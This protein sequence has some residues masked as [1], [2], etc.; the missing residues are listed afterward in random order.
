MAEDG[1][2]SGDAARQA[3]DDLQV[4]CVHC[5][6]GYETRVAERISQIHPDI[7]ALAVIQE[8]HRSVNGVKGI[9]RQVMLPGYVFL[10]TAQPI[11]YR[12]ILPMQ[13]V[14]R[15][16]TYGQ[17][18]DLVLRGDDLA[19]AQWVRRHEG[20]MACSRAVQVGSSLRIVSGPL[21]DHIGTVSR[22][23]RHNRNVCLD[24]VFSGILRKVWM[25][26]QWAEEAD[27]TGMIE[28]DEQ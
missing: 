2:S 9:K 3:A 18:E 1:V 21:A 16:L 6:T 5:A 27:I 19:F 7:A 28:L 13:H 8:K 17:G 24:I 4:Y 26:F 15:F 12:R 20:L 14:L 10:F 22:V 23:D 11:P 25:P